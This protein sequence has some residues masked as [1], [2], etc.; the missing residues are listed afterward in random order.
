MCGIVGLI[1]NR[2]S[3]VVGYEIQSM[4]DKIQHRGP[5]SNGIF[6]DRNVGLGFVRLSILD[7]SD[8]SSQPFYSEDGNLIMVFNG[9]MFNYVEIRNELIQLGKTFSTSGDTEVL[10]KSYQQWGVEAFHRLNG[11]WSFVIY[12]KVTGDVVG[13][14]DRFGIKPFYY[15]HDNT[16]LAFASE[17][18]A[19]LTLIP[20]NRR[21]NHTAV[22]DFLV[23]NKTEHGRDTFFQ[24]VYKLQPGHYFR[25]NVFQ[26]EQEL[27]VKAW[28]NLI[29]NVQVNNSD[30]EKIEKDF[31][32][33]L[34]S[35]VQLR[36]RS[37]VEVGICLSGGLDSSTVLAL[38]LEHH[39]GHQKI[40]T[41]SAVFPQLKTDETRYILE[42]NREEIH[43]NFITPDVNGLMQELDELITCHAEP[44][45]SPSPYAQFK[46]MQLMKGKIKVAL[47]GQGAD[48]F[49]IGYDY[50]FGVLFKELFLKGRWWA[51]VF[52]MISYLKRHRSFFAFGYFV[53]FLMPS[54]W[55]DRLAVKRLQYLNPKFVSENNRKS[56]ISNGLY[57]AKTILS[58]SILH[59]KFKLE[60][61]LKWEDRNSMWHSIEARVP[62]LDHRL[63]EMALSIPTNQKID[64]GKTKVVLR[65]VMRGRV[66]DNIIDRVDKNGF[67][68][69]SNQWMKS[70]EWR[71]LVNEII[72]S[73]SFKSRPWWDAGQCKILFDQFIKGEKTIANEIWKWVHLELW[74]RKFEVSHD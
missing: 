22:F 40:Q 36:M 38:M 37:D 4:M 10:L 67:D 12:D 11:M 48:E 72:Q 56:E 54:S 62:F 63:V 60:H 20:N 74:M 47:D 25:Y 3:S 53:F 13:C 42:N 41:F 49:L 70:E 1:K 44:F 61:L 27:E 73:D 50:F 34:N 8:A 23:Y 31:F 33:L 32:G 9:E 68:T 21:A 39:S 24:N 17:I 45:P 28:Y 65:K 14:R 5:D 59:Y 52:Q 19:L 57:G 64:Q 15:I 35:S 16:Q 66:S 46:V 6:V 71:I 26:T 69:P 2:E 51:L 55:R 29:E 18:P 30:K 7:L 58:S 43:Q